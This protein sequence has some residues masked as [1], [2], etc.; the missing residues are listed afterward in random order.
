[1]HGTLSAEL[2]PGQTLQV[3]TDGGVTWFNALVEGTQWA[4]QDLNEHAVNWTIQTR[5]MDSVW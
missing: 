1:M 5:V 4:A 2:V 3:S